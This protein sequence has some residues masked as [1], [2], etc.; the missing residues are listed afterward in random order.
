MVMIYGS[1]SGS[2]SGSASGSGYM[3]KL[4]Q[5]NFSLIKVRINGQ[6]VYLLNKIFLFYIY[7]YIYLI[8]AF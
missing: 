3:W 8:R 7:I 6:A 5:I 2:D 4:I 1:D